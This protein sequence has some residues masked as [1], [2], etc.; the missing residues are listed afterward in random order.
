MIILNEAVKSYKLNK[1]LKFVKNINNKTL[2]ETS[3]F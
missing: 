3:F 1:S 2:K